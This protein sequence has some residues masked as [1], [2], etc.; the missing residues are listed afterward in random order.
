MRGQWQDV[1]VSLAGFYN[2]SDLGVRTEVV[3]LGDVRISRAPQRN[4]GVEATIDW[5]PSDTWQLGSIFSWN[6]GDSDPDN[7]GN[8]IAIRTADVQPLKLTTYVENETL[9]GWR[10]RLQGL[11]VGGRDRGFEAGVD[12]AEIDSYFVLDY[13]S[14]VELGFGSLQIGVHNLLDT[15]YFAVGDQLF[16]PFSLTNRRAAPGRTFSIGYRAEF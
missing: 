11:Y 1:Q 9:P 6:E 2:E 8:F 7:N 15:Q 4:Y 5:Q 10:N 3:A 14:S 12:A 16:A 13:I